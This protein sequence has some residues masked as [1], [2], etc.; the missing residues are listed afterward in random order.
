MKTLASICLVFILSAQGFAQRVGV[1]ADP[2][3]YGLKGYSFHGLIWF[4][5]WT[6]DAGLFGAQP[7]EA[8]HG[9]D[10]FTVK[11]TGFGVKLMRTFPSVPG[12]YAGIGSGLITTKAEFRKTS[13][14]K[15][16]QSI[17]IGPLVGYRYFFSGTGSELRSGFYLAPWV[18][19][20]YN[21]HFDK[22]RFNTENFNQ[23][24]WTVFPTLHI[25]Y[26]F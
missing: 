17:G 13:E 4:E 21:F 7:P 6:A 23:Q 10:G 22:V 16:G 12:L 1:E 25:G 14:T 9:N 11:M 15:S 19:V 26:L 2:I 18:S 8:Y 20:D 24:V 5:K 3:A